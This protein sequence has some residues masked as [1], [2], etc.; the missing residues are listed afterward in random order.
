[1]DGAAPL[2]HTH[3]HVGVGESSVPLTP[4]TQLL[5]EPNVRQVARDEQGERHG[6]SR[7]KHGQR[8]DANDAHPTVGP[9]RAPAT[10]NG[11]LLTTPP[12]KPHAPKYSMKVPL[13]AGR[14]HE[15]ATGM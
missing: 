6:H 14:R 2:H 5:V 15:R 12:V 8:Q 3:L 1:M 13:M 11:G 4:L 9:V 7:P 10:H